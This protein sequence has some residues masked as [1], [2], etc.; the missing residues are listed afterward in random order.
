MTAPS[1]GFNTAVSSFACAGTNATLGTSGQQLRASN[2]TA[3]S[4]WSMSI[5]ATGGSNSLWPD[6]VGNF[7]DFNDPTGSPAGCSAGTDSDTYAGLL[8]VDF[9]GAQIA[10]QAGC[11]TTGLSFGPAANFD[12]GTSDALTLLTANG[13]APTGC[14]WDLTGVD[15]SQQIPSEQT[16]GSYS[17]NLTVTV[18][19]N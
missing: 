2:T 19:A 13:S 7:Y 5:A 16:P 1:F 11:S 4:N 10:P 6:G 8:G 9:S 15:L 14:Y 12:E 17:L 3:S 18:V